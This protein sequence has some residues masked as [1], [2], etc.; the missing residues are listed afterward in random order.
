MMRESW[1]VALDTLRANP[2]RTLLSTLG[3][4]DHENENA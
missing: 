3:V 1:R 4:A 2:L